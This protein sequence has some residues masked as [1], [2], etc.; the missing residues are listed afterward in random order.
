M[1]SILLELVILQEAISAR[2]SITIKQ[3]ITLQTQLR[4][5]EKKQEYRILF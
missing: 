5:G 4:N 3:E 1:P 2:N